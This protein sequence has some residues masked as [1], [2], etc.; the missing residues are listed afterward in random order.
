MDEKE[1]D[2]VLQQ[3]NDNK[4]WYQ[5]ISVEPTM[6]LYMMAFM[7]TSVVENVFFVYKSCTVNHGYSHEICINIEKYN[8][9]KAEVQQTTT[10][11]LQ[12]NSIAGQIIPIMLALFIGSFS[13]RR[14]R[15]L[16]LVMGLIGKFVYSS[17]IV[18]NSLMTTWPV[19]YII[20]T[21]TIP[22]AMT[23]AD[24]AIFASAFTYIADISTQNDRTMRITIL[25]VVYL[26]TMPSGVFIGKYLYNHLSK[27]FTKMFIINASL[28]FLS[29]LYSLIMLD[30]QTT[31][32]QRPLTEIPKRQWLTDFFDKKHFQQSIRSLT[33]KRDF[34]YRTYL[35][36][37]MVSMGLYAIQRDEKRYLFLFA[38]Y[39][40]NWTTDV[41]S[42]FRTFQ[43]ASYV[44]VMLIAV[45]IFNK[46]LK[47]KDTIIVAIGA[48]GHAFGRMFF[49]FAPSTAFMYAGATVAS[50]GPI[51]AP[52]L[53]SI[54]S[55]LIPSDE[56]GTV[57]ALLS[58]CDNAMPLISGIFYSQIYLATM[59]TYPAAI[60]WLTISSQVLV[61]SCIM[62]IHFNRRK[63]EHD[64]QKKLNVDALIEQSPENA[65][66][67]DSK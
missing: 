5:K 63:R 61:F 51:V 33:K 67:L 66:S 21:A 65:E 14:G 41:Y 8:E 28:L 11:F 44:L 32:K 37:M 56:R 12:Y 10:K 54:T 16:P 57:F 50:F 26:S 6:F 31:Q 53:R 58:V 1:L 7:L 46:V 19:E 36:L 18:V 25:D 20:Y 62:F 13:D 4:K 34:N 30:W 22:S 52:A 60:F 38:Q 29:I 35:I 48:C 39:K 45:P 3:T 49:V 24:V 55:K 64:E 42:D 27:S 43:S 59:K 40:L 2:N 15:K 17:M 47:W 23:G 9:T